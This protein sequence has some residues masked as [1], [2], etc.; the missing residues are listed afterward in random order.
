LSRVDEEGADF[1]RAH[2]SGM[3]FPMEKAKG[4]QPIHTGLFRAV[5]IPFEVQFFAQRVEKF[6]G[7]TT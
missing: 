6:L 3:A 4:A 5:R 2:L 1:D 7:N